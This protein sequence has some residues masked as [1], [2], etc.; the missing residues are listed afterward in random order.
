[1]GRSSG[2]A[3]TL[4]PSREVRRQHLRSLS[5]ASGIADGG[6]DDLCLTG[7]EQKVCWSSF[8]SVK[9]LSESLALPCWK[10]RGRTS[11]ASINSGRFGI[12]D[13]DLWLTEVLC[14]L[15]RAVVWHLRESLGK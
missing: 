10:G 4:D 15:F 7:M 6:I 14:R 1:M 2:N 11:A 3:I 12:F 13:L 8:N 5:I 9:A